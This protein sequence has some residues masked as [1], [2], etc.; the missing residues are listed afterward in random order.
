MEIAV[1]IRDAAMDWREAV[2]SKVGRRVGA[3]ISTAF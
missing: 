2:F 3:L 1:F